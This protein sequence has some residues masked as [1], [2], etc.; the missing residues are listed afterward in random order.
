MFCA[1]AEPA[2]KA[3][4]SF[5]VCPKDGAGGGVGAGAGGDVEA[6]GGVGAGGCV[7]V[8][9]R[10]GGCWDDDVRFDEEERGIL[11]LYIVLVLFRWSANKSVVCNP[12]PV[13]VGEMRMLALSGQIHL[14]LLISVLVEHLSRH[15]RMRDVPASFCYEKRGASLTTLP[16]AHAFELQEVV[17]V[18]IPFRADPVPLPTVEGQIQQIRRSPFYL[19]HSIALSPLYTDTLAPLNRDNL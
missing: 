13:V 2:P 6:G 14:Y 8:R 16:T 18:R 3:N 4:P 12:K 11:L 17:L 19:P 9:I 5:K 7:G 1:I 15:L 10:P